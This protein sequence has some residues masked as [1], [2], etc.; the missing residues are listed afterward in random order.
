MTGQAHHQDLSHATALNSDKRQA[1]DPSTCAADGTLHVPQLASPPFDNP[2]ADTILRSV[3]NVHFRVFRGILTTVSPFFSSM[4]ALPQPSSPNAHPQG[5]PIVDVSEASDTLDV[6][7][8]L[9]YPFPTSPTFASF[10]D[11]KRV[12][13]AMH[14]F[15]VAWH[16][17]LLTPALLPHIQDDPIRVY[18][19]AV[20]YAFDDLA[21]LAARQT[22]LLEDL[23]QW[24]SELRDITGEEFQRLLI[25]RK[26]AITVVSAVA[27]SLSVFWCPSA[28]C[29]VRWTWLRCIR[30]TI[31]QVNCFDCDTCACRAVA[32]WFG[33][34]WYQLSTMIRTTPTPAAL[35]LPPA[36]TAVRSLGATVNCADCRGA[37]MEEIPRFLVLL[38]NEWEQAISK[39]SLNCSPCVLDL[40]SFCGP[41]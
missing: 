11:A 20:R 16:S 15:Q 26:Q 31:H 38:G 8:R 14:K 4:F 13:E 36:I 34:F 39:V 19:F 27:S 17:S 6:F 1:D 28:E 29:P 2:D 10:D 9:C 25:Y 7:L 40:M 22:L 37:I 5:A 30:C 18:A 32:V 33:T 23:S 12:L 21:L 35:K 24:C 3:D 41:R